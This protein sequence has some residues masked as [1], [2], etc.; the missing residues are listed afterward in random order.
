MPVMT[1]LLISTSCKWWRRMPHKL[2]IRTFCYRMQPAVLTRAALTIVGDNGIPSVTPRS[3]KS[4]NQVTRTSSAGTARKNPRRRMAGSPQYQLSDRAVESLQPTPPDPEGTPAGAPIRATTVRE[5]FAAKA[6]YYTVSELVQRGRRR[7]RLADLIYQ[8]HG[9][10]DDSL[11][12]AGHRE[13]LGIGELAAKG[14]GAG[15]AEILHEQRVR[16]H[17]QCGGLQIAAG[18][19]GEDKDRLRQLAI[20][21]VAG[22]GYRE[23]GAVAHGREGARYDHRRGGGH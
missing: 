12:D 1:S 5:W 21:H 3:K 17:R 11:C 18:S 20:G 22:E 16:R 19:R 8:G 6:Q 14:C 13:R 2:Y 15:A 23:P 10:G 9:Y 4:G 7:S